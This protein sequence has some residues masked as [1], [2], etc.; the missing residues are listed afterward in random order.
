MTASTFENI[1][2][3]KT[4]NCNGTTWV[5]RSSKTAHVWGTP[6]RWFFFSK[7]DMCTV[8]SGYLTLS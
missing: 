2:V 1:Q 8:H 4:F 5:K 3:G 6:H 7:K